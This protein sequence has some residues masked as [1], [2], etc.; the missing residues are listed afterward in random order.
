M[1]CVRV[2]WLFEVE[3]GRNCSTGVGYCS[4][5]TAIVDSALGDNLPYI[6]RREYV[7]GVDK[8]L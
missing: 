3:G 6:A 4:I 7:L 1:V 8:D 5:G 2:E